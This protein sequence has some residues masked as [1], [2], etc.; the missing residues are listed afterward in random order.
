MSS[1]ISLIPKSENYQISNIKAE[2]Q[3]KPIK[4]LQQEILSLNIPQNGVETS[5]GFIFTWEEPTD[6]KFNYY[7][8]SDIKIKNTIKPIKNK[9]KFPIPK[10]QIQDVITYLQPTQTIKSDHQM[11]INKASE[12]VQG[13]DDTYIVAVKIADWIKNNI[14]YDLNTLTAE[15]VQDAVWVINNKKGVCDEITVLYLSMLRSLG[16]PAKYSYGVAYS[17]LPQYEDYVSHA[18]S[19]V[20]FPEYGWI[21]FDVTFGQFGYIDS[22]H[23]KLGESIGTNK[24]SVAFSW[25]SYNV[26]IKTNKLDI[27]ASIKDIQPNS[28]KLVEIK[29]E[30]EKLNIGPNSYN[31]IVVNVENKYNFYVSTEL[32]LSHPKELFSEFKTKTVYLKPHQKKTTYFIVKTPNNIEKKIVYKYPISVFTSRNTT[33]STFFQSTISDPIFTKSEIDGLINELGEEKQKT[34]SSELDFKC[35]IKD[36]TLYFDELTFVECN[37]QNLGN[38]YLKDLNICIK[39]DCKSFDLPISHEFVEKLEFKDTSGKSGNKE[40]TITLR[41]KDVLKKQDIKYLLLD[42]PKLE[43]TNPE[44]PQI[45]NI[46]DT[47]PIKVLINKN[48]FSNPKNIKIGLDSQYLNREKLLKITTTDINMVFQDVSAKTLNPGQNK[49]N[50]IVEYQDDK[51]NTYKE[52]KEIT[53]TLENITFMNKIT[54]FFVHLLG[55]Y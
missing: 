11:I 46:D 43:I 45:V 48:S 28:Y 2:L 21:P 52:Q 33:S 37:V 54:L 49:I 50:V 4:N 35:E 36:N 19:E 10:S 6:K 18:W 31:L 25:M 9:I 16:I 24:S 20:Y 34:Y 7:I 5:D 51:G 38:I 3:L 44:Y 39:T 32:R 40:V 8:D 13:E 12:I 1:S 27:K 53:I 15:S 41:N 26:D 14:D 22:S 29:V 23:I 30:P 42:K 47:F 55:L 17:N